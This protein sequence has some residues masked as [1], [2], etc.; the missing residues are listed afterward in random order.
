MGVALVEHANNH[1]KQSQAALVEL[2]AKNA[3]D[4]AYQVADVYA[5]LG[6]PD[7]AFE[8][9]E[10]AY[11]QRDSGLNGVAYDPLLAGLQN[12]VRYRALLKKLGLSD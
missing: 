1:D 11:L 6:D 3:G 4:M 5:W 12:D 9:L 8:W 2:I 7:K 10:R